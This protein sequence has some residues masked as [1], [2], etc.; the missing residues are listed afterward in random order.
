MGNSSLILG[1]HILEF[2]SFVASER[3]RPLILRFLLRRGQPP[4]TPQQPTDRPSLSVTN[5]LEILTRRSAGGY[6][7][8]V[9]IRRVSWQLCIY[10][11]ELVETSL[12]FDC[13]FSSYIASSAIRSKRSMSPGSKHIPLAVPIL[14]DSTYG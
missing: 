4:L 11:L 6:T 1:Q 8:G 9:Q 3:S 5:H 13:F 2:R 14:T 10:L 12:F 7:M